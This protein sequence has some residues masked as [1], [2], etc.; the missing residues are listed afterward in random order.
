MQDQFIGK[1]KVV[2]FTYSIQDE[3]GEIVE[4]L[5]ELEA[6][7]LD[8]INFIMPT[9]RQWEMCEE[10]ARDVIQGYPNH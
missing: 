7:G 3:S 6:Q 4:Q 8:G 1:D 2:S 10:F 9:D 5:V